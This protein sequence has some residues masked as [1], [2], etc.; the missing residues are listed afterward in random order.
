M[1]KNTLVVFIKNSHF[2]SNETISFLPKLE[3]TNDELTWFGRFQFFFAHNT[4]FYLQQAIST[5]DRYLAVYWGVTLVEDL[6]QSKLQ[7]NSKSNL[8]LI[9]GEQYSGS[10]LLECFAG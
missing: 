2:R 6:D 1:S 10:V 5:L 7:I 4:I 8:T 9:S 3:A